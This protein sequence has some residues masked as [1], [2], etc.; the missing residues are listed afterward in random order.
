MELAVFL[1]V[2]CKFIVNVVSLVR[3]L[4]ALVLANKSLVAA[5]AFF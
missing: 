1:A 3:V 4:A 5:K 2:L